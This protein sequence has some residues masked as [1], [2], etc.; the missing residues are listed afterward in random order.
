MKKL[1]FN[2]TRFLNLIC[3]LLFVLL[4][5][6]ASW[7][8]TQTLG[9]FPHMDGGFEGQTATV[10]ITGTSNATTWSV[11]SQSNSV[12]RS[13]VS[14]ASARSG[15]KYAE[16]TTNTS[17]G[18]R[19]QSPTLAGSLSANTDYVVQY[20]YNTATNPTASG[21]QG[22][23]YTNSK[24]SKANAV[25]TTF[26]A[27]TWCKATAVCKVTATLDVTGT[28]D[29]FAAVRTSVLAASTHLYD[30]F[31]VYPGTTVDN[32]APSVVTL[33]TATIASATTFNI[34]WTASADAD[35]TGYMVV[36]YS[37]NP[38]ANASAVPNVNGVYAVGNTIPNGSITGTV[39]YIG[40]G[41]S[42]T[43]T[44][45]S[46]GTQFYYRIFTVDKAFNYSSPSD[47]TTALD[48]TP[49]GNPGLVSIGSTTTSSLAVSWLAATS[50]DGGGY[51][52]VRYE[53]NPNADNGPTQK[54]TYVAGNS[55]TNGTGSLK[56]TV[57]YVGTGLTVTD[58]G[59]TPSTSYYYKVYTF[60]QA[61][62][63]SGESTENGT[64]ASGV[65]VDDTPPNNP[66]AVTIS[67]QTTSS[68]TA[69]WVPATGGYDGGGYMVLR[70]SGVPDADANPVQKTTYAIGD[71]IA[72]LGSINPKTARVVYVGTNLSTTNTLLEEGN[73]YYFRVYTFDQAYNYSGAS[74]V[75]GRTSSQLA[76]PVASAATAPSDVVFNANWGTVTSA[77]GYDVTIYNSTNAT[78]T[79]VGW[80]VPSTVADTS[81]LIADPITA[82]EN[83]KSKTLIQNAVGTINTSVSGN[84]SSVF[85]ARGAGYYST[86]L[87]SGTEALNPVYAPAKTPPDRYWQ[88]EVNT[89]GYKN[90]TISS[91]QYSTATGPRDWKLQYSST[92]TAGTFTDLV[93]TITLG[94]ALWNTTAVSNVA[95]PASCQNNA[96]VVL[97]WVQT[98]FKNTN[99]LDMTVPSTGGTSRIDNILVKG[100]KLDLV[101]TVSAIGNATSSIEITGLTGGNYYYDVVA[102]GTTTT[103][104]SG[105]VSTFANS[106]NSNVIL[107]A[108][109]VPQAYGAFRS[110]GNVSLSTATNW[111]YNNGTNWYTATEAPSSTNNITV[112][113]G[114]ILTLGANFTLALGKT[115]T[116]NG[117]IDLAGY[118]ISGAGTFTLATAGTVSTTSAADYATIKLGNNVSLAAGIT[119]TTKN[120][121]AAANYIYNGATTQYLTSLPATITG[122]LTI[123]N[124]STDGVYLVQHT[125]INTPGVVTVATGTKLWFGDG[126]ATNTA[127]AGRGTFNLTGTGSFTAGNGCTLVATGSRGFSLGSGNMAIRGTRTWGTDINFWFYKNDGYTVMQMGDLFASEI[128]SINNLVVNNPFGVYL[129][130]GT[131]TSTNSI[132]NMITDFAPLTNITINGDLIFISGK[133]IANNG[134]AKLSS[135][136]VA[137]PWYPVVEGVAS[138]TA[139]A[140]SVPSNV[141]TATVIVA[142]S[143]IDAG[144]G[145]TTFPNG[146]T[147][148][149]WVVGNLKKL[150]TSGSSASFTYP[151]GDATTYLPVAVTFS[152][153]TSASG[154]LTARSYDGFLSNVAD[155]GIDIIKKVNRYWSLTNTNLAGFGTY[156]VTLNYASIDNDASTTPSNYVVRR[157]DNASWNTATISGTPSNTATSVSGLSA[158]GDFTIG[159]SNNEAPIASEQ[160][161]CGGATVADLEPAAGN[162]YKWYSTEAGGTALTA[163]TVL[164]S[165]TYYVSRSFSGT[166]ETARTA[167]AITVNANAS[168][169]VVQVSSIAA[170]QTEVNNANCGDIFILAAGSY[171]NTVLNVNSSNITIKAAND[172]TG[173]FLNGTND[174]NIK[175]NYVK[176]IGFQFTSGDIGAK[177]VIDVDGSHNTLSQLNFSG[178]AAGK[179]IDI[180]ANTQY[181][182]IEYCNISKPADSNPLEVG[183]AIQIHAYSAAAG[184][185]KIRYCSF[186]NFGGDGG[187]YGNE[188]I[189]IGLSTENYNSRTIVEYCYFNNTGFGDSESVSIKSHENTVRFCTFTEQQNAMLVF[190]NGNN[191]VAYSNFFIN[192]G[193]IRVKEANNIYCYNNYFQN[194]GTATTGINL[195]NAVTY[196]YDPTTTFPFVLKN[197]NFV[198]NTFYDCG[199][200]DFSSWEAIDN[201]WANNIFKK[202]T[203]S[204]FEQA[205]SGI[206]FVGNMYQGTLGLTIASGMANTNPN[207]ALNSDGFYGL[208]AGS[209]AIDASSASYPALLHI[210]NIDDDANLLFDVSG[211]SRPSQA[212]KKDVGADE[213]TTGTTTN[214]PLILT[215]VGPAYLGG[216]ATAAPTALAQAFC[217]SGTVADLVAT[218]TAIQWY[219]AATGGDVLTSTTALSAGTYYASQTLNGAESARTAVAVTIQAAPNAGTDGSLNVATGVIPTESQLFAA[220]TGADTGGSWTN[221]GLIYTY[222][223]AAIA[224]CTES[225]TATVTVSEVIPASFTVCAG[226]TIS[227]IVGT[228]SLKFYAD[229]KAVLPLP[230]TTVLAAKP[231]FVTQLVGGV[232]STP[233]KSVP[234]V[235]NALPAAPSAVV[236]TNDNAVLPA[237]STT[238]VT[239][240]GLYAGTETPFKL[241][242]TAVGAVSYKWTLP[243]GVERTNATGTTTDASRT[244]TDAFIYVKFT[245]KGAATPLVM[246]VQSVNANGCTSVAKPS[247]ALTRVLP[248]AP[249]AIVVTDASLAVAEGK[250]PTPVKSFGMYMGSP[251]VL[252]LTA[253]PSPTATSYIWELPAGVTQLSGGTSNVITV[254]FEGVTNVNTANY[255]DTKGILTHV[256]RI[257]VKAVNGVGSS[258]TDNQ[259]KPLTPPTDSKAKLLVLTATA[260]TAPALV[261]NNPLLEVAVGA[262]PLAITVI[263]KLI[264]QGAIYRL[265]AAVSPLASSYSWE[266]P[267]CVTRVTDVNGLTATASTT[268]IEPF[269]FVKFDVATAPAGSIYFGV[270]AVNGVGS[271]NSSALN[272]EIKSPGKV[273][274]EFSLLRLLT[275]APAAP[276]L[277]LNNPLLQVAPGAKPVAIAIISKLIGQGAVYRLTAAVSPLANSYTWELPSCVSR[278]TDV[279]GLT[280][281][282]SAT[283]IEPFIFVKF[284][285]ATAPAGSIY[286]GVKAVNG[287]G[288]SNSS[289]VNT[290]IKVP[291]KGGS[292]FSLLKLITVVPAAPASLI[293]NDVNSVTPATPIA[294]VSK[295][296]ASNATLK[297]TAGASVLANAYSWELPSCVSRVTNLDGLEVDNSSTST[298]PFIYVKFNG[299]TPAA[300]LIYFGVKAVN[301]VGSSLTVNIGATS[302]R[303]DKVLAVTA[304][305][306]SA[307]AKLGGS[308]SV[309]DRTQGF[310][311]TITAPL[312]A[313]SYII[314]APLGSVV[315]STTAPNN[316][317]NVLATSDLTFK[318]VYAGT[319]PFSKTDNVLLITSVNDFG[320]SAKAFKSAALTKQLNCSSLIGTAR[321][322]ASSIT[323]TFNVI[324]YPNP[325][326]DVFTLEVQS[327]GKGKAT[328]NVQVYDM[329]G[330][331]IEQRQAVSK[332]VEIGSNYPTGI[333]NVIVNQGDDTK[334]VRLIKK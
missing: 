14:G 257:G 116:V 64:T 299:T 327:S 171:T 264:G 47:I 231:Y 158:F 227:A 220:L 254:N 2:E 123:S 146:Y 230:L 33:P 128:T 82:S 19:L 275:V 197:V 252:T 323:E 5:V 240:L 297:L 163:S 69:S 38:A 112:T 177:N 223:V 214:R 180:G 118:V 272:T 331:L 185:H 212:I 6:N 164:S 101:K 59:L 153:N 152:G 186:Q 263:S 151:I 73:N 243:S 202:T 284:D 142:G 201:T 74:T 333:Y 172:G 93:P 30:D 199:K 125:A 102:K 315:S 305:L 198:H 149:K 293:L 224:P 273:G 80:T 46:T 134:S 300:G 42:F 17:G 262:K 99:N 11:S 237:T 166:G 100:E 57:I 36:R 244:S 292:E 92:G 314:T 311:Y 62:N 55:Y 37:S 81:F 48:N 159:Q 277:V 35:K 183:C 90:A 22:A 276:A 154:G 208:S 274:S 226:T 51:M 184:Y 137:T 334:T 204:I 20:Y 1:L 117:I 76:T 87:T 157:F 256:L 235:V 85:S 248:A 234:V 194:S 144:V 260:P 39:A 54:T 286:F 250:L 207:L 291:G 25:A 7:G 232:E 308:L 321:M 189:R 10:A 84:P 329:T 216:P 306:P 147:D 309:C 104:G 271:S 249:A 58:S 174:I 168:S 18:V 34:G 66:G 247:A 221:N 290:E 228:S 131:V 285:V 279:N 324:A 332:S 296:I 109:P 4:G 203:G 61:Y 280:A 162:S 41:T 265:T 178:Y 278:V 139:R 155:S 239:A 238:A 303:T 121:P 70:F 26:V 129:P 143:I 31:V 283:S 307:V 298:E 175:G 126:Q 288:S 108:M 328:T 267:S 122:N 200:I 145:T 161:F 13:I 282:T 225:D 319:A 211:Q 28:G 320:V 24:T 124:S 215:N 191:N 179:Y 281:T 43:D 330:R 16:H 94:S 75:T 310:S 96:S 52:V 60:D 261:L 115:L 287:V 132:N 114:H 95:L 236:L 165:G 187:D 206:T 68:L 56:G 133:L 192:A 88:I 241:T 312:D 217:T 270:K 295:Y 138:T 32:T 176:F 246:S 29:P 141:G 173:V 326:T 23:I 304:G 301:G 196:E 86:F 195:A 97:R 67:N 268:S 98:S 111:E 63:Y 40:V 229:A 259:T 103:S 169:R 253:T 182:T 127:V 325:S 105:V 269:I 289:I 83:N 77:T 251:K 313:K 218:G 150:T 45:T 79:I 89:V 318:V 27:S 21:L 106:V 317:S 188:P 110:T 140:T 209:P 12:T 316:T 167:V 148:G 71:N 156:Q 53:S 113:S 65:V 255:L 213:F 258:I 170:L 78:S 50:V 190:R 136:G 219:A 181:N 3:S 205:N 119:T 72:L 130:S 49:P 222:T 302:A 9:S 44:V 160:S 266:L 245:E 294:I 242:A 135:P 8:Q 210:T 15:S 322:A 91:D 107:Y 193:G 233:R 120:F